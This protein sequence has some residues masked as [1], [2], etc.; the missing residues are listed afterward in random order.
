MKKKEQK[1]IRKLGQ[2]RLKTE[3]K[4]LWKRGHKQQ[5]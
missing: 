5:E 1:E 2:G 3:K 4:T